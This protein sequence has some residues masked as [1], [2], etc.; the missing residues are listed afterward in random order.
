MRRMATSGGN[1]FVLEDVG[2]A[3][4]Q[5]LFGDGSDGGGF[6]DAV[7]VEERG[8][9]HAHT[10]GDGE[11]G[12]DGEGEGDD[13]DSDVGF[14]EAE[15]AA[16]LAPLAHVPGDDEEDGGEGGERDEARQRRSGDEDDQ[17]REGVDDAG[18]GGER[19]GADV[20]SGAGDG[21]G[22]GDSPEERRGD[23]GD[24]LRNQ[25]DVGVVTVAGHAVR[26]DGGEQAFDGA[27]HRDG[28]GRGEE[29]EDVLRAEVREGEGRE[30]A[31][32]AAEAG[33]DGFDV[34]ME[35]G[36]GGGAGEARREWSRGCVD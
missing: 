8:E 27:Q 21:A 22:G 17:Q 23:V 26:D 7:D 2:L 34:E 25:L 19:A 30:A 11:V 28:E 15:D 1:F 31:R 32:N 29:W 5:I 3:V 9:R 4:A 6:G 14:G 12:D 35:Q 20:G 24:A 16:D 13:P 33:A 36:G 18:D 10:D